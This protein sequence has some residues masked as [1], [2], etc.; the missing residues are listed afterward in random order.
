MGSFIERG[1]YSF[2]VCRAERSFAR[3]GAMSELP[4]DVGLVGREVRSAA[5]PEWGVGKVL[6]VQRVRG[7]DAPV[8]RVSVQFAVG[9]RMLLAPPARLLHPEPEA[10]RDPGWLESLGGTTLDDLLRDLPESITQQLAAPADRIAALAPLYAHTDDPTSLLKWAR[11]QTGTADP[12]EHWTRDELQIAFE[13]FCRAR[14]DR[15]RAIC[16]P[17]RRAQ[18]PS[19][20]TE[21]IEQLAPDAR[22][23]MLHALGDQR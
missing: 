19:A 6:R 15:L 18:G 13:Q 4:V 20:V 5:R 3:V 7:G 23:R 9:H 16:A 11:S 14:D 8:F 10:Q 2:R 12:L 17:L 1:F 22:A 21:L